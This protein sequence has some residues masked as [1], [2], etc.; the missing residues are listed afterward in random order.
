[1]SRHAYE[2]HAGEPY[3]VEAPVRAA[4]LLQMFVTLRPLPDYNGLIGAALA[5]RYLHESGEPVSPPPGGMASL[6]SGIRQGSLN[7]R[8][9]AALLRSWNRTADCTVPGPRSQRGLT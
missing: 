1:M 9:A 2:L 7:L 6:V 4:V 8:A 5:V 3:Y